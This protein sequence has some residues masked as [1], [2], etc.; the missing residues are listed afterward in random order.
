MLRSRPFQNWAMQKVV[1]T[2]SEE[3]KTKVTLKSIDFELIN[4]LVLEGLYVE[5]QQG[6]TLAY[7]WK[8]KG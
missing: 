7:F 1:K 6:D 3:L 5:D 2:L 8:T 4:N